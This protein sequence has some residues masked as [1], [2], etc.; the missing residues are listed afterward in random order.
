MPEEMDCKD[1]F[2]QMRKPYKEVKAGDILF[3]PIEDDVQDMIPKASAQTEDS[4]MRQR[5]L[6]YC[7]EHPEDVECK[8]YDV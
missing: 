6:Q 8:I 3:A 7:D 2:C 1:G 4:K 5:F